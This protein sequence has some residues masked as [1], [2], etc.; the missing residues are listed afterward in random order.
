MFIF[1][2]SHRL[3]LLGLEAFRPEVDKEEHP[4]GIPAGLFY[5]TAP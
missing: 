2:L 1:I 4:Y 3:V 5:G